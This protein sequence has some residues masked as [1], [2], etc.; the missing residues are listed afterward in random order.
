MLFPFPSFSQTLMQESFFTGFAFHNQSTISTKT[1]TTKN[2][3]EFNSLEKF[4]LKNQSSK[5][6]WI[7]K[8]GLSHANL[9][10]FVFF[11]FLVS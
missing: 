11:L 3:S 2:V 4:N 7:L 9:L 1:S 10:K 5:F 6:S 8:N